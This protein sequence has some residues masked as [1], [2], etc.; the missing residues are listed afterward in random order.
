MKLE[1]RLPPLRVLWAAAGALVALHFASGAVRMSLGPSVERWTQMWNLDGESNVPTWFG[2]VL[3]LLAAVAA[4]QRARR[5]EARPVA[6]GLRLLATVLLV[7]SVDE[8]AMGHERVAAALLE[9]AV[10]PVWVWGLGGVLVAILGVAFVD[11]LRRLPR[12]LAL[13]FVGAGAVYVGGALVVEAAG[14]AFARAHGYWSP[15]YVAL[16]GLEETLEMAGVLLFLGAC[17][18]E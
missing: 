11:L 2:S 6:R 7:L 1:L 4:A 8:V 13:R 3:L 14:H 17:G 5:T 10:A 15:G 12:A 9:R 18:A 16:A